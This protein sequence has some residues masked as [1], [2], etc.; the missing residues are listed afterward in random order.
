M[1]KC[2]V[3]TLQTHTINKI[4]TLCILIINK[5]HHNNIIHHNHMLILITTRK[6]LSLVP[7]K[8]RLHI[9][10][11]LNIPQVPNIRLCDPFS[12]APHRLSGRWR[13]DA[14]EGHGDPS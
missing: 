6:S 9:R 10:Q 13:W 1:K 12:R 11:V 14:E 5:F 2:H 4:L 8:V 7:D 3:L